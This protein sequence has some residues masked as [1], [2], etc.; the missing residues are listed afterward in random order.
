MKLA[1][2]GIILKKTNNLK[3]LGV[4]ILFLFAIDG[5]ACKCA[6]RSLEESIETTKF[7]F[8]GKIISREGKTYTVDPY[9]GWK[10]DLPLDAPHKFVQGSTNCEKMWLEPSKEYVFF[11]NGRSVSMCS[12]TIEYCDTSFFLDQIR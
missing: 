6:T 5:S 12:R 7:I 2:H 1:I 3:Y 4:F 8:V 9:K 11:T 10:G